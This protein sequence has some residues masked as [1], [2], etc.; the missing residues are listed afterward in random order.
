MKTVSN[1]FSLRFLSYFLDLK[2]SKKTFLE[3]KPPANQEAKVNY[4]ILHLIQQS[5]DEMQNKYCYLVTT[6]VFILRQVTFTI[7][8]EFQIIQ[9]CF[10]F[11]FFLKDVLE[12][13]LEMLSHRPKMSTLSPCWTT[14]YPSTISGILIQSSKNECS[15]A[16]NE[17]KRLYT[18]L[19]N[20]LLWSMAVSLIHRWSVQDL[21]RCDT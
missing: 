16:T 1:W 15:I 4:K 12:K 6:V 20:M 21:F 5:F 2:V 18:L 10:F 3:P 7:I 17:P 14:N 8:Q 19:F 11:F 13:V 9:T